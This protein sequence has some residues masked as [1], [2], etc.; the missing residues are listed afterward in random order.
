MSSAIKL[1]LYAVL[2][3]FSSCL[4]N[5]RLSRSKNLAAH[6]ACE[7]F[8]IGEA[9]LIHWKA[10]SLGI[11]GFRNQIVRMLESSDSLIGFDEPC[12]MQ[13]LGVPSKMPF[14]TVNGYGYTYYVYYRKPS[15]ANSWLNLY[16]DTTHHVVSTGYMIE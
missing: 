12:I 15:G 3:V 4:S 7:T 11:E 2:V 16:F 5:N 14:V 8:P 9:D 1:S 13:H 6:R 10:D